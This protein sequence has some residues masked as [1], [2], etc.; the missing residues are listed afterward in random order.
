MCKFAGMDFHEK[1]MLRCIDLAQNGKGFVEP[2]PYVGAV[3]VCRDEII[4]EGYHRGFGQDH[5]EVIAIRNAEKNG[6]LETTDPISLYVN[7]EP[8][9]HHGKTPPCTEL[10]LKYPII[11]TVIVSCKDPNPLVSG[12]GIAKL[13]SSGVDVIE[14][15]S[16]EKCKQLNRVF[17]TFHQHRRPYIIL[18]WAQTVDGF[19]ASPAIPLPTPT[20]PFPHP[21]SPTPSPTLPQMGK[22]ENKGGISNKY[23]RKLVHKWRTEC[24]AIMVGTNTAIDDNPMLNVREWQGKNPLRVVLDRELKIPRHYHLFD[25]SQPTVCFNQQLDEKNGLLEFVKL[26]FDTSLLAKIL[27]WLY[28]HQIQSVLVEGGAMLLNEFL[29]QNKWDE[30]RVFSSGNSCIEGLRAPEIRAHVS[31]VHQI[32]GDTLRIYFANTGG[33]LR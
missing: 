33:F 13:K 8:C 9:V 2:N 21:T 14:G 17:L 29:T 22:G 3:L 16:E 31:E 26:K 23:S 11:R 20:L 18:K 12:K 25:Q 7:L 4:G 10:I 30:A 5:A 6:L 1:F 32:D 27:Q 19:M 28:E 24:Q 15:I